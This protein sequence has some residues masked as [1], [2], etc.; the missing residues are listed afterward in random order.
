MTQKVPNSQAEENTPTALLQFPTTFPIKIVGD[1]VETFKSEILQ[2]TQRHF[3]DFN[4]DKDVSLDLSKSGKYVSI[5]VTVLARSQEQLDEVY[6]AY[7]SNPHAKFV[8]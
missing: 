2:I 8:L 7:T 6:R 5:T 4:A 3:D 1:N